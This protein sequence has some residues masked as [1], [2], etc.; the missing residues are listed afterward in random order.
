MEASIITGSF[1]LLGVG[2][3]VALEPLRNAFA[4]RARARAARV[5]HCVHLIESAMSSRALLLELNRR[6]RQGGDESMETLVEQY[7]SARRDLR[8]V[9]AVLQMFGPD[10]LVAAALRVREADRALR[11]TR[12]HRVDDGPQD[13]DHLPD[14]V[15]AAAELLEREVSAFAFTARRYI[16]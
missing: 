6:N 4:A 5:E 8:H 15:R 16:D 7:R 3:G 9:T 10:D 12:F 11:G 2:L 13:P 14:S 1:V